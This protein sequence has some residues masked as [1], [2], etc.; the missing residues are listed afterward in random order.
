MSELQ[1]Q[2]HQGSLGRASGAALEA[3]LDRIL[4]LS[5]L[6]HNPHPSV[7]ALINNIS[8]PV[9]QTNEL[10]ACPSLING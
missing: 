6:I 2:L 7:V 3:F 4:I 9:W 8:S 1:Q 5:F 10:S